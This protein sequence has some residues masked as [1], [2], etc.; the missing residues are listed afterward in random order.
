MRRLAAVI[1]GIIVLSTVEISW[2]LNVQLEPGPG[3]NRYGYINQG[4][5]PMCAPTAT[6]NSFIYLSSLTGNNNLM[7]GAANWPAAVAVI[8]GANYMNTG[9]NGTTVTNFVDGKVN[10]INMFSPNT[11]VY[12]GQTKLY[13]N[14]YP[15]WL[16]NADP[17]GA[18]LA[19]M[20]MKGQDVE[21][22]IWPTPQDPANPYYEPILGNFGHTLTLTGV[23]WNDANNNNL[24]DAGD[25]YSITVIDPA[26]ANALAP[27]TANYNVALIGGV[28]QIQYGV[29]P[30][31]Y[32]I[33]LS[34]AESAVPEPSTFLLLGAGLGGLALIRRRSHIS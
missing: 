15:A 10:Y 3:G 25:L 18:F 24:F 8:A 22:G 23:N 14:P 7:G 31:P 12:E 13:G 32:D 33:K 26:V 16:Q 29:N 28:M 17:T 34:V 30:A 2:G 5:Q 19:S 6:V 4:V 27:A 1:F 11:F 20:L 21:L 9:Q